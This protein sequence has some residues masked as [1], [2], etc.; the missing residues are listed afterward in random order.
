MTINPFTSSLFLYLELN[1]GSFLA[2]A[3]EGDI[4]TVDQLLQEGMPLHVA[5]ALGYTALHDASSANKTDVIK[6]LLQAGA[7]V[8]IKSNTWNSPLMQATTSGSVEAARLLLENGAD[9]NLK[10]K[11]KITPLDMT[12]K[13]YISDEI[14]LLFL[15][16]QQSVP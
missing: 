5:D 3:R 10:N 15:E 13:S 1:A 14:K 2:A 11:N 12:N 4:R 8:D 7:D 6:R 9:I 16:H